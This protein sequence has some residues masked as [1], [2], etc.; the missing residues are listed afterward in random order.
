MR[1]SHRVSG[2]DSVGVE[3]V[4]RLRVEWSFWVP[5]GAGESRTESRWK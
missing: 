5:E 2:V 1:G 3:R 4:L